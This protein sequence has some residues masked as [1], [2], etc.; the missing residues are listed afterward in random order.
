MSSIEHYF[1]DSGFSWTIS[2]A[3][4]Y[5]LAILLGFIFLY[6]FR[7]RFKKNALLKWSLRLVF[8]TLPFGIYFYYSPIYQGD[9]SNAGV[10]IERDST[11]AE[12]TGEK[13]VVIAIPGCPFCMEAMDRME[14]LKE[15]VPGAVIEYRICS[16]DSVALDWYL[17]NAG[18]G[19][20]ITLA[21]SVQVMSELA[22]HR[23]PSFVLVKGDN[24]PLKRWSNDS[25]GVSALDEVEL[26][27]K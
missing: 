6:L 24:R 17:K 25:F 26:A 20:Q 22:E 2:K 18:E 4:P 1:L 27:L 19:I 13:L 23:F 10:E 7:K 3:L 8:L 21:D 5:I 12:L 11:Y 16:T 15:R 9:F 14:L